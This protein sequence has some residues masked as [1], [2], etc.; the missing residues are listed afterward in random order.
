MRSLTNTRGP[1]SNESRITGVCPACSSAFAVVDPMYPAPPVTRIFMATT[2]VPVISASARRAN[3]WLP[4]TM[5]PC[6]RFSFLASRVD[7]AVTS[8][9]PPLMPE[10]LFCARRAGTRTST[11]QQEGDEDDR[12]AV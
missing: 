6:E 9:R 12:A 2:L 8:A 7:H 11:L 4:A 1:I 5:G 3:G 10:G